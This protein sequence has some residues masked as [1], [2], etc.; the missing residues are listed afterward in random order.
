MANQRI[1]ISELPAI[2][3]SR[4]AGP[5][6]PSVKDGDTLP[7]AV[8]SKAD[9]TV[10][11]TMAVTTREMRRYILQ[12][13]PT[14]VEEKDGDGNDTTLTIAPGLTVYVKTLS[15]DDITYKTLQSSGVGASQKMTNLQVTALTSDTAITV[16]STVIPGSSY[17]ASGTLAN[18]LMVANSSGIYTGFSTSFQGLVEGSGGK[19]TASTNN[20]NLV[21]VN[22]DGKF[23]FT[24]SAYGVLRAA[25]SVASNPSGVEN[26]A[27]LKVNTNGSILPDT[28][29]KASDIKTATDAVTATFDNASI[30]DQK[31]LVTTASTPNLDDIKVASDAAIK[32]V[33]D[34]N[35]AD[36][37]DGNEMTTTGNSS[38]KKRVVLQSPLVLGYKHKDGEDLTERTVSQN[39]PAVVGEIRW[40]IFNNIPTLYLAVQVD[41][42]NPNSGDYQ[43]C[44]WYGVPLF[45]TIDDSISA[46]LTSVV[47]EA[48]TRIGGYYNEDGTNPS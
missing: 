43:S 15:A 22:A 6:T 23:Q 44:D 5:T 2:G 20:G 12:Q 32:L 16:G 29:L 1:K 13:E 38:N 25:G 40:N 19:A 36:N 26:D 17:N 37:A 14:T 11:R 39:Y 4:T 21:T 8:S 31:L 10:K 27:I 41:S 47:D 7:L 9:E 24:Q 48:G 33:T 28:T 45:G 46:D 34:V 42:T 3:Y 35:P 18:G 30:T